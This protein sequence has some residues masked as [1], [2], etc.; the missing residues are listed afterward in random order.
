MR[1]FLATAAIALVMIAG[2]KSNAAKIADES[3]VGI[4]ASTKAAETW[5]R[6]VVPLMER[7]QEQTAQALADAYR[8][9]AAGDAESKAVAKGRVDELQASWDALRAAMRADGETRVAELRRLYDIHGLAMDVVAIEQMANVPADLFGLPPL[10]A[11]PTKGDPPPEPADGSNPW[12]S[13]EAI[14]LYLL[15][16]GAAAEAER[17]RRKRRAEDDAKREAEKDARRMEQAREA[18]REANREQIEQL[19]KA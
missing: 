14:T 13:P 17:R 1:R 5:N 12:Q 9:G 2:C 6:V 8:A 4:R 10:V 18:A 7:I 16:G 15:L 19:G 11:G 3:T